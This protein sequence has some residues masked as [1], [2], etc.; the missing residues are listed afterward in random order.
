MQVFIS[1]SQSDEPLVQQL[2]KELR[3]A[4]LSVWSAQ[5]S[6]FPGDNW[7]LETGKALETSDV[8]VALFSRGIP[9]GIPGSEVAREVQ[10]AL[11]SGNYRGRVVP[12]LVDFT[13]YKLGPEVPWVV[14][15][16]DPV[17]I[18]RNEPEFAEIV[19]RVQQAAGAESHASE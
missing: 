13:T 7:P 2:T 18:H 8:M 4:G 9:G 6:L 10:Y 19:R 12:V 5:E 3:K 1:H 16:L 15:K 14:E 11:T 17:R